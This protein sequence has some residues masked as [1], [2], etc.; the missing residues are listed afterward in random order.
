MRDQMRCYGFFYRS[1][2]TFSITFDVDRERLAKSFDGLE[3]MGDIV[4]VLLTIERMPDTSGKAA[5]APTAPGACAGHPNDG[6]QG[7]GETP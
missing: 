7:E 3:D 4:P 2:Q 6:A 1:S 5:Q